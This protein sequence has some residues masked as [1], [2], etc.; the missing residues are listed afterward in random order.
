MPHVTIEY[1]ILIPLLFAQ[2]LVFPLAASIMTSNWA[3]SH[4]DATLKDAANY[5]A[6]TIQQL[7][8]S[9]NR[10]ETLAGTITQASNLPLTVDSYP[11]VAV[12]SLRTSSAIFREIVNKYA[13][14][15]ACSAWLSIS[16][17]TH[18]GF[19]LSFAI[20]KTSLGPAIESIATSPKTNCL[21][22]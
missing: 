3:D 13:Q 15:G 16:A 9:A 8:L 14:P 20:I 4:R 18:A 17:A 2:I 6:S 7:Y 22:V 19:A 21:A 1:V 11:Y 5:L 10:E 12:G